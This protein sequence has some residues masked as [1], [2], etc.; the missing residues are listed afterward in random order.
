LADIGN[1]LAVEALF[2]LEPR[3]ADKGVPTI[4]PSRSAWAALVAGPIS[5]LAEAFAD[6]WCFQVKARVVQLRPWCA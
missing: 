2:A 5:A 6:C 3:G 1:P 4:L